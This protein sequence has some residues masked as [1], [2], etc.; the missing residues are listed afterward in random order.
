VISQDWVVQYEGR[1]LQIERQSRYAPAGGKVTV[2]EGR[3][4]GSAAV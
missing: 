1:W 2:S 4:G 3:D